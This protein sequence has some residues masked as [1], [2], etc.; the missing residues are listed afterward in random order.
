MF[1]T[2]ISDDELSPVSDDIDMV[3]DNRDLSC[4]NL[5]LIPVMLS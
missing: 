5:E 1:D 2:D 4:K 3:K